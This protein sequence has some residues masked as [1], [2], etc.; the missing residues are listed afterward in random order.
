MQSIFL[1]WIFSVENPETHHT[2]E[3]YNFKYTRLTN[4]TALIHDNKDL[5]SFLKFLCIEHLK[6]THRKTKKRYWRIIKKVLNVL[7]GFDFTKIKINDSYPLFGNIY[8]K[9]LFCLEKKNNIYKIH[10][11][12]HKIVGEPD[13][14]F[15]DPEY[16][17]LYT[18]L[19]VNFF[20][21]I[22]IP[23]LTEFYNIFLIL[24]SRYEFNKKNNVSQNSEY[25]SNLSK[26]L[27]D[28]K[29]E[30]ENEMIVV[31]DDEISDDE[32]DDE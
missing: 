6:Y 8:R 2:H 10:I 13:D 9:G 18:Y 19:S 26:M 4:N 7:N 11:R 14:V 21:E 30:R 32:N 15:D 22:G 20:Y 29:F 23:L 16:R 3:T 28:I 31:D 17:D 25:L 27:L 5:V 1:G 12:E 24:R